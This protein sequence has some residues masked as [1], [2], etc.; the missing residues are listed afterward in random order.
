LIRM[1]KAWFRRNPALAI[2][3]GQVLSIV[4]FLGMWQFLSLYVIDKFWISSPVDI[5]TT[6]IRWILSSDFWF[7]LNIT[8]YEIVVGFILGGGLGVV[9]GFVLGQYELLGKIFDPLLV[10]SYGVPRSALAPL[11]IL[12]FGIGLKS[13]IAQAAVMVFFVAFF[14]TFAGVKSVD[15]DFI[16]VAKILGANEKQI[17]RKI[18]LPAAFP[19]IITGLKVGLPMALIGA[20]VAEFISS[21]KGIGYLI[22]RS[23]GMFDTAGTFAGIFTLLFVVMIINALLNIVEKHVLRW[24]PAGKYAGSAE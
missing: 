19:F 20:V 1:F 15:L 8:L 7:H 5:F 17:V 18:K 23:T 3:S 2:F 9:L 21:N 12:W 13:K 16:N 10:A 24:R 14:N 4:A 6:L 11:F 22:M